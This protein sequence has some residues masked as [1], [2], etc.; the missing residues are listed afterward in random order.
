M[1]QAYLDLMYCRGKVTTVMRVHSIL[2][3]LKTKID[4]LLCPLAQQSHL[5]TAEPESQVCEMLKY[6]NVALRSKRKDEHVIESERAVW[7]LTAEVLDNV[8]K[9]SVAHAKKQRAKHRKIENS[10]RRTKTRKPQTRKN[11]KNARKN[12]HRNTTKTRMVSHKSRK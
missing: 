5:D 2:K 6:Q 4:S 1:M 10:K 9:V 8:F 3:N 7:N 12:K 11:K